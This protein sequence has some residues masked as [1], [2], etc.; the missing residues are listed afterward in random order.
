MGAVPRGSHDAAPGHDAIC[1]A[2]LEGRADIDARSG[3]H[4]TPLM[5]AA[6]LGSSERFQKVKSEEEIA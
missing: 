4:D 2:L 1:R 3:Q 6:H 5:W